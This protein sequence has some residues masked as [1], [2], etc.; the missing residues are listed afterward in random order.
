[1]SEEKQPTNQYTDQ[2]WQEELKAQNQHLTSMMN[3]AKVK[4]FDKIMSLTEQLSN[5]DDTIRSILQASGYQNVRDLMAA[6]PEI[7]PQNRQAINPPVS[8]TQEKTPVDGKAVK[9]SSK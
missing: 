7:H 4:A 8:D 6:L 5:A 3:A 1:M 9:S 2:Q